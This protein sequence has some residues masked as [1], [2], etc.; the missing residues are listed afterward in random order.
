LRRDRNPLYEKQRKKR[1]KVPFFPQSVRGE[2]GGNGWHKGREE[3]GE[4]PIKNR[5]DVQ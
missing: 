2:G 4:N 3:E 5:L 1:K